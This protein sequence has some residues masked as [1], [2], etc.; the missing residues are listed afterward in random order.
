MLPAL[1]DD[2]GR[3]VDLILSSMSGEAGV[4]AGE[5]SAGRSAASQRERVRRVRSLLGLLDAYTVADPPGDLVGRTLD[6]IR[7]HRRAER[8]QGSEV[9]TMAAAGSA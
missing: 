5:P 4:V 7:R 6:R 8:A 3:V 9:G 2:D 1:N